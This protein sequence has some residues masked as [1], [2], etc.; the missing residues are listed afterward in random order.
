[1]NFGGSN[2]RN[3]LTLFFVFSTPVFFSIIVPASI[4][5]GKRDLC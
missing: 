4:S 2:E 3:N 1:M 5:S